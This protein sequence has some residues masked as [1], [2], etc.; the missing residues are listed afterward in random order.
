[1]ECEG[2]E[3]VLHL[4]EGPPDR[5][6]RMEFD[7]TYRGAANDYIYRF[8]EGWIEGI[9]EFGRKIQDEIEPCPVGYACGTEKDKP[10]PCP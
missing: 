9:C 3:R 8:V 7:I 10:Y 6:T 5:K 1:M 4:G 2:R